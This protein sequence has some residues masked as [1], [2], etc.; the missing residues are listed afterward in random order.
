MFG[1]TSA[2]Y[3]VYGVHMNNPLIHLGE[4][5]TVALNHAG[6]SENTA[7]KRSGIPR[8]T[9]RRRLI[10]GDF[11]HGELWQIATLLDTT[12]A[13]LMARAEKRAA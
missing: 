9:L 3:V 10:T 1:L 13:D 2:T 6:L 8:Q 4:V 5:V 12:P 7:S 11:K